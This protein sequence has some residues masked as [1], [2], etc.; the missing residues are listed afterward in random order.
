MPNNCFL[1]T[2][3]H[4]KDFAPIVQ[5]P[6]PCWPVHTCTW[7][8]GRKQKLNR[9]LLSHPVFMEQV[10]PLLTWFSKKKAL[11]PSGNCNLFVPAS[12]QTKLFSFL[13]QLIQDPVMKLRRT[14]CLLLSQT[15][16]VKHNG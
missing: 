14:C 4:L 5:Q 2:I 12:I 10:C 16:S 9:M 6:A 8:D 1:Q 11:K 13:Q 3:Q 15:I 7:E